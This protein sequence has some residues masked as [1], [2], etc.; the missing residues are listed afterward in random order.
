VTDLYKNLVRI[1]VTDWVRKPIYVYV[2]FFLVLVLVWKMF[3]P[4]LVIELVFQYFSGVFSAVGA[5]W[6]RQQG[7]TVN[8][9]HTS[10][11]TGE[12]MSAQLKVSLHHVAT[13]GPS[14]IHHS[15]CC[16]H[17]EEPCHQQKA[18]SEV[19]KRNVHHF[20]FE[21]QVWPW[22]SL[23]FDGLTNFSHVD[24]M[25]SN[26]MQYV[27]TFSEH[28]SLRVLFVLLWC[29]HSSLWYSAH[30]ILYTEQSQ[31]EV[32]PHIVH[33]SC[34]QPSGRIILGRLRRTPRHEKRR[35]LTTS[36]SLSCR[37][38][39]PA[40]GPLTPV[41]GRVTLNWYQTKTWWMIQNR[42]YYDKTETK[43]KEGDKRPVGCWSRALG[44]Q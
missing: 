37:V 19:A 8:N 27:L 15:A 22:S 14:S 1:S 16:L 40:E 26:T 11:W 2:L 6:R 9:H 38:T 12:L 43:M 29:I 39:R 4:L 10:V 5:S 24:L 36:H 34:W 17:R 33:P 28:A 44:Q 3:Q 25:H 20:V 21:R 35:L 41:T 23:M 13:W 18:Y 31:A 7:G 32:T 30:G 42:W